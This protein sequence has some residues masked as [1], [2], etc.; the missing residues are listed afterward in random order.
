M[1]QLVQGPAKRMGWGMEDGGGRSVVQALQRMDAKTGI[2]CGRRIG[3]Y[4]DEQAGGIQ[5]IRFQ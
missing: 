3:S 1:R 5:Q 2:E 4:K